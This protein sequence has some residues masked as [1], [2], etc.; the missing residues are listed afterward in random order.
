[1]SAERSDSESPVGVRVVV[2]EDDGVL[3]EELSRLV[4][5]VPGFELCG[6]GSTLDEGLELLA[7]APDVV[8]LDLG[9][10]D[11]SGLDLIGRVREAGLDCRILV[12]TVFAD[13]RSVVTAIEAGADGYLLKESTVE[14]VAA[15]IE[16]VM[17]GG[18]PIS[19]AVASH[20]LARVRGDGGRAAPAPRHDVGLTPREV[21]ILQELA[22]GRSLKEVAVLHGIS[23]H[24]V[25]D[26]VK[27]I[28]RKLA[29]NSRSQAV[30]KA[31]RFGIIRIRD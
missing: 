5:Q 12:L 2:V 8:L 16:V 17:T 10:P 25:G 18:A 31:V 30:N 21:E 9:L 20:I 28:Y 26:H 14:Q 29:V 11:G 1:M 22:G 6:A 4:G 13:V 27:A 15:A 23:H 24:T 19:P 7:L 3:R